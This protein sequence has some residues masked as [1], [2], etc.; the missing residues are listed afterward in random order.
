[1]RRAESSLCEREDEYE[2]ECV[3]G[4][5]YVNKRGA[6]KIYETGHGQVEWV[7]VAEGAVPMWKATILLRLRDH[8]QTLGFG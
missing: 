8:P 2:Y 4:R 3:G 5:E 7:I 6:E 1:M